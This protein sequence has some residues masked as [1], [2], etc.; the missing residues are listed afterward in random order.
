MLLLDCIKSFN[1]T[2]Y[3]ILFQGWM[4]QSSRSKRVRKEKR[5]QRPPLLPLLGNPKRTKLHNYNT[6]AEDTGH[7]HTIS[8]ISVRPLDSQLVDYMGHV[9]V[10]SLTPLSPPT[11]PPPPPEDYPGSGQYWTVKRC[12]FINQ[13]L[14]MFGTDV[15]Q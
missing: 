13:L 9:F 8:L 4:K 5:S 7:T 12:T 1:K 10:F 3:N 2:K 6:H 14:K 11:H 15:F